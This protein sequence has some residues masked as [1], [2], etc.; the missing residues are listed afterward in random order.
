MKLLDFV[1]NILANRELKNR[2]LV[3]AFILAIFRLLAHVPVP[4]VD[5]TQ[6]R[7]LFSSNQLLGLLDIFSGGTLANFSVVAL[8]LGPYINAS[9]IMQMLTAIYPKLEELQQ[10]GESGREQINQYT[11]L[12]SVP[13]AIVQSIAMY[14][15]LNNLN[16]IS[17]ANPLSLLALIITMTAGSVFL[18]WLGEILTEYGIGNG[19]SML[20][21]AGIVGRLPVAFAQTTVTAQALNVFNLLVFLGMALF[22]IFAIVFI[23]EARREVP[24]QYSRRVRGNREVGGGTSYLP[25]KLNTAGVIP[26]IFALAIML[27]PSMASRFLQLIPNP[28]LSLFFQN[29]AASFTPDSAIYNI[30]YFLLVVAFTYFYTAIVFDTG[31]I[32]D[33][34][35]KNG[36]FV[37]GIRPGRHTASY[38]SRIV[39]RTTFAG[40][41]FLGLVA[42]LPSI[43][44]GVTNISTISI[45][46]TGILIV[47][48]VIVETARKVE[49]YFV[50][51][52]Y[53]GFL[54]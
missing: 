39:S 31:K 30:L 40:A 22:V 24:V 32:A 5:A 13:L 33:N 28:N 6:L 12:A 54:N 49:T 53:E 3:T 52:S 17:V 23:D 36:G 46:G 18:M 7:A 44:Q 47:V 10:E 29:F 14:A 15:L 48:S 34:L 11:R 8:G 25:I 37:P 38:L 35:K 16:L 42:V 50:S 43:I 27:V 1:K 45:G 51:R 41:V 4:G 9:I 19:I 26:I 2:F 20:I 21:F